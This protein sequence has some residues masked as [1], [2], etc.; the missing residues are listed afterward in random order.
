MRAQRPHAYTHSCKFMFCYDTTVVPEISVN[1]SSVTRGNNC[2]LLNQTFT[3]TYGSIHLDLGF[4]P[5]IK[6]T[7]RLACG[8]RLVTGARF[9]LVQVNQTPGLYAG[10][11]VYSGPSFCPNFYGRFLLRGH[12]L[13]LDI[14]VLP[15]GNKRAT[16][17]AECI[18]FYIFVSSVLTSY[19]LS[20]FWGLVL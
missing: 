9:P 1:S 6:L 19:F 2:K 11:G 4:N 13:I 7:S 8:T 3:T 18:V 15:S 20:Y 10:P 14:L 17:S 12:L 16:S 5:R